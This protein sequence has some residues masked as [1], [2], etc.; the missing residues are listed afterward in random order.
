MRGLA[1]FFYVPVCVTTMRSVGAGPASAII[2]GMADRSCTVRVA[3]NSSRRSCRVTHV[4]RRKV[5][6][7][8]CAVSFRRRPESRRPATRHSHSF[9]G[10]PWC[11]YAPVSLALCLATLLAAC[12]PS[13]AEPAPVVDTRPSQ[14]EFTLPTVSANA[15]NPAPTPS[16]QDVAAAIAH[17]AP[18]ADD[19]PET[20]VSRELVA[21][22]RVSRAW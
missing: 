5:G 9:L 18:G 14:E 8:L 6:K 7:I 11:G 3:H 17:D 21:T 4:L 12:A 10:V 16:T 22:W 15:A 2:A 1:V 20:V 19:S 13:Q